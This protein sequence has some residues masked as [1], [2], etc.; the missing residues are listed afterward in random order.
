[1]QFIRATIAAALF[2]LLGTTVL[3][4]RNKDSRTKK[5]GKPEKQQGRGQQEC[6]AICATAAPSR[7]SRKGRRNTADRTG[8]ANRNSSRHGQ[9]NTATSAAAGRTAST[10]ATPAAAGRAASTAATPAAAG[11]TASTAATPAAAGRTASTAATSAAAGRTASTT[12]TPAAARRTVPTAAP[13]TAAGRN[14]LSSSNQA[15][16]SSRPS[17]WQQQR[18]WVQQGG[19]QGHAPWQQNRTQQLGKRPS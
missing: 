16:R 17:A 8:G 2:L 5:Q 4:L 1:M 6:A 11:R 3:R 12:A 7:G 15:V 10:A 19:W 18:G 13:A 9:P 14:S